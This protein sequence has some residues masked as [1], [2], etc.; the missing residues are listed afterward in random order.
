MEQKQIYSLLA[1][2]AIV[3]VLISVGAFSLLKSN[4]IGPQ[5]ETGEKGIQGI[6]GTQGVQGDEGIQGIQGIKGIQGEQG[7]P[8]VLDGSW[9][10]VDI[11]FFDDSYYEM[12]DRVIY[13]TFESDIWSFEYTD[14]S[15]G[16][17]SRYNPWCNI[18]VYSGHL[19][20]AEID[21]AYSQYHMRSDGE[22]Q[23][24]TIIGFGAGE[25][26][27]VCSVISEDGYLSFDQYL[28]GGDS[29]GGLPS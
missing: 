1:V 9:E 24:D 11:Y 29:E 17:S 20:N 15:F 19:T 7:D 13:V 28:I 3:S 8:W 25:Y 18:Q 27:F 6:Q 14:S 2:T 22:Y 5:G 10:I 16:G 4:F 23:S 26:T 21:S 12:Y